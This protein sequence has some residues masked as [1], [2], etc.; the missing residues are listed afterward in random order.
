MHLF[1][2]QKSMRLVYDFQLIR[3]HTFPNLLQAQLYVEERFGVPLAVWFHIPHRLPVPT[4]A[5][6]RQQLAKQFAFLIHLYV[7]RVPRKEI[8]SVYSQ[9]TAGLSR[10]TQRNF[11]TDFLDNIQKTMPIDYLIALKRDSIISFL[12]R[13][14]REHAVETLLGYMGQHATADEIRVHIEAFYAREIA[15]QK[16]HI[17]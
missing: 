11:T 17:S 10:L 9:Y 5:T 14:H 16:E 2:Y 4:T 13:D 7:M 3:E 6:E 15:P 12:A 1:C 8:T